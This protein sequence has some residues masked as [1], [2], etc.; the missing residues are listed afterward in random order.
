MGD[1]IAQ[2]FGSAEEDRYPGSRHSRR[3]PAE[4]VAEPWRQDYYE[5]TVWGRTYRLYA[6][7][8]VA[9]A[10]GVSVPTLRLW[11][12]NSFIPE[13][14]YRLPSNMIVGGEKAV[15]RRLYSEEMIDALV[16]I[17]D[18]HGLLGRKRIMWTQYPE[19]PIEV[20]ETWTAIFQRDKSRSPVSD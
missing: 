7:G 15:G 4:Y 17:F 19:I 11:E 20:H 14:P 10:M 3:P 1:L 6:I 18:K 5:K 12:K 13:A 2:M 16:E 9:E 8:S